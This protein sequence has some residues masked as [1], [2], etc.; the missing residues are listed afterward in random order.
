MKR[1]TYLWPYLR[2][3]KRKLIL[4]IL[5]IL[6]SVILGMMSPLLLGRAIDAL[7]GDVGRSALSV[8]AGLIVGASL[9]QGIFS[10]LQR[11]IL[12]SMSR[13]IELDLRNL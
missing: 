3:H 10:Y 8:Y 6:A 12:V 9:V 2:S 1:L 13:D 7:R 4:G 5:S 11:M